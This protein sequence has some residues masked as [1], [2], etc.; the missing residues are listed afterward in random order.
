MQPQF[1]IIQSI[2]Y[3]HRSCEK[4][5]FQKGIQFAMHNHLKTLLVTV[6]ARTFK[7]ITVRKLA[8]LSFVASQFYSCG[9]LGQLALT[10]FV[11]EQ[12]VNCTLCFRHSKFTVSSQVLKNLLTSYCLDPVS[13]VL[14]GLLVASCRYLYLICKQMWSKYRLNKKLQRAQSV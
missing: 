6:M 4:Y 8:C 7:T 3:L 14:F 9:Q 13:Y 12:A 10:R 2:Q 1:V 5:C 11:F